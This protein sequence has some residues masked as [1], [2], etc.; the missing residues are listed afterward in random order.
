MKS[1]LIEKLIAH[2]STILLLRIYQTNMQI[3]M[4]NNAHFSI[5]IWQTLEKC[6]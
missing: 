5:Y 1:T 4:Y 3:S 6:K 2:H